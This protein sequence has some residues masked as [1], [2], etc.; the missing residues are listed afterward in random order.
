MQQ[1][2]LYFCGTLLFTY[3][4][5]A[6]ARHETET[7]TSAEARHQTETRLRVQVPKHVIRVPKH[8]IITR[9]EARHQRLRLS[10]GTSRLSVMYDVPRHLSMSNLT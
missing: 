7:E 5:S 10:H 6:E 8:V 4:S 3:Y 1:C 2:E 9:A